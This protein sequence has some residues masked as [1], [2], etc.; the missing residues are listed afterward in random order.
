MAEEEA[1][2]VEP[3]PEPE[4]EASCDAPPP[5]PVEAPKDVAEEKSVIPPPAEEKPDDTKALAIVESNSLTLIITAEGFYLFHYLLVCA[6]ILFW[7]FS[8]LRW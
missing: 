2:K 1:K 8:F 7:L 3:E 5:E 6:S 4:P